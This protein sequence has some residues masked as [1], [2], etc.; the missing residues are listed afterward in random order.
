MDKTTRSLCEL[1]GLDVTE[2]EESDVHVAVYRPLLCFTVWAAAV[3]YK[4]RQV[5]LLPGVYDAVLRRK[6]SAVEL[7]K[8]TEIYFVISD[9]V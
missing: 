5:A 7:E 3:V 6:S 2:G 9:L 8:T 4:P 1:T